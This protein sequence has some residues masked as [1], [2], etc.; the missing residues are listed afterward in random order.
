MTR[1]KLEF[2]VRRPLAACS[3]DS[4]DLSTYTS[5]Q[6]LLKTTQGLN[7]PDAT[8]AKCNAYQ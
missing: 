7:G 1:Q 4:I 3:T 6:M 8:F 5:E 2:A